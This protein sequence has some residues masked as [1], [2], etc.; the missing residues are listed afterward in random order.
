MFPCEYCGVVLKTQK[1]IDGHLCKR[2][3]LIRDAGPSGMVKAYEL[4]DFWIRYGGIAR[5]SRTMDQFTNSP[6]FSLFVDLNNFVTREKISGKTYL[7]W[8]IDSKI[9][10]H[11]WMKQEVVKAFTRHGATHGSLSETLV[12]SLKFMAKRCDE[13]GVDIS[14]FFT[15]VGPSE[16]LQFIRDGKISPWIIF[17]SPKSSSVLDRMSQEQANFITDFIDVE[18]WERKMATEKTEEAERILRELGL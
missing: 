4:F 7:K 6:Y 3:K 12:S 8:L 9:K 18:E 2:K 11:Q 5:K 1:G 10:S 16:C 15:S 17:L 14:D 13:V